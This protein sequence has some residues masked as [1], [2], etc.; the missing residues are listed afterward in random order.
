MPSTS[1][2]GRTGYQGG[3][4]D[5]M[6]YDAIQK[7]KQRS[8]EAGM[9]SQALGA[10]GTQQAS[11]QQHEVKMQAQSLQAQEQ[12]QVED[13]RAKESDRQLKTIMQERDQKFATFYQDR[14]FRRKDQIEAGAR[15]DL[16]QARQD[17]MELDIINRQLTENRTEND[18]RMLGT[19]MEE[20]RLDDVKREQLRQGM[21]IQRDGLRLRKDERDR[22]EELLTTYITPIKLSE[23]TAGDLVATPMVDEGA[24]TI[25]SEMWG[26]PVDKIVG[27][28]VKQLANNKYTYREL[29]DFSGQPDKM[30]KM[31]DEGTLT[32]TDLV[33]IGL[34][35]DKALQFF[36][37]SE[38]LESPEVEDRIATE[39][40]R[41]GEIKAGLASLG[42]GEYSNK[43]KQTIQQ[44]QETV[45]GVNWA[46]KQKAAMEEAGLTDLNAGSLQMIM[47]EYFAMPKDPQLVK[48]QADIKS[49]LATRLEEAKARQTSLGGTSLGDMQGALGGETVGRMPQGRAPR[50]RMPLGRRSSRRR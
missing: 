18:M 5:P 25:T 28:L 33:H 17:N 10:K 15:V 35:A 31:I 24:L 34:I 45:I 9:Q 36:G 21:D 3:G 20:G 16:L 4:V 37:T 8:H 11:Q 38:T 1:Q 14:S 27:G 32:V 46:E 2:V 48:A 19:L 13:L 26:D 42:Y 29:R 30:A 44:A 23:I 50:G 12:M 40:A 6:L 47:D 41:V 39:Y 7:G 49:K 43:V 22:A